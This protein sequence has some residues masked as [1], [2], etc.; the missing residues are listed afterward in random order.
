[1]PKS[2]QRDDAGQSGVPA[3]TGIA[4]PVGGLVEPLLRAAI[5]PITRTDQ[6]TAKGQFDQS[7]GE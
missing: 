4:D 5:Q 2:A 1:M 7:E 3:D 6:E